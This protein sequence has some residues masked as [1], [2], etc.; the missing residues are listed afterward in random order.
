MNIRKSIRV[1]CAMRDMTQEQ[2]AKES[3][4][5]ESSISKLINGKAMCKQVTLEAL[6]NTFDMPVSEFVSLGE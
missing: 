4:V 3:G 2:V 5:S 6:A 1:A